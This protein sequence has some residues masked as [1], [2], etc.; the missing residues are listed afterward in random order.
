MAADAVSTAMMVTSQRHV[1]RVRLEMEPYLSINVTLMC[2]SIKASWRGIKGVG[3]WNAGRCYDEKMLQKWM[4]ARRLAENAT[5]Q[6]Q[7]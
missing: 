7:D 4:K 3:L 5:N 6:M 2:L 1:V